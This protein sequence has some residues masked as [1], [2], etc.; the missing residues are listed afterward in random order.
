MK[1]TKKQLDRKGNPVAA[2]PVARSSS[3]QRRPYQS[4]NDSNVDGS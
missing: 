1:S 2:S 3:G 4:E